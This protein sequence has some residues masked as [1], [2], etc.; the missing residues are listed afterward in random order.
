MYASSSL[1]LFPSRAYYCIF[2]PRARTLAH[3]NAEPYPGSPLVSCFHPARPRSLANEKTATRRL[4]SFSPFLLSSSSLLYPSHSSAPL[5]LALF[6]S[7]DVPPL[8]L[9]LISISISSPSPL[10]PLVTGSNPETNHPRLKPPSHSLRCPEREHL[11]TLLM[12]L[13][14]VSSA[15]PA[16]TDANGIVT[17]TDVA[18]SPSSPSG[19]TWIRPTFFI[20]LL[21]APPNELAREGVVVVVPSFAFKLD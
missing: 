21:L 4:P 15:S 6:Y 19:V 5:S 13:L 3:S 11:P 20:P 7:L 12:F 17:T 10:Y 2:C 1:V 8:S 9:S 16:A 14:S 18:F